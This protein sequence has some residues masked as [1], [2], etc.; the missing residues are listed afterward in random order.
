MQ[1][2]SRICSHLWL[3]Q[4]YRRCSA[5]C[6]IALLGINVWTS[7]SVNPL[8]AWAEEPSP[9]TP[10]TTGSSIEDR[11][12]WNPL[13]WKWVPTT[14]EIQKY[15]KSWNP[16]A[17]GPI[18]ISGV[19]IQPEGQFLFQPFVFGEFGHQKFGNQFST[20]PSD[21]PVH[22]KAVAPTGI[23][24]Y[25]ITNHLEV[26]VAFSGIYW[27]AS[28][29]NN[30]GGRTSESET[31]LG[32]TTIYLKYRPIVQDPEGWRP[33]LTIY[34][35]IALPSSEWAG[36]QGIPGGFSPLGRLPATRFGA[37][38]F[39]EGL[40]FRKN[41][42]PFRISGGVFYTYTAPGNTA[43][44]NTYPGD[45]IN[46]RLIIEH[47]LNDDRGFGYNLE[48]VTLNGLSHRL[49]GKTVNVLPTNYALVGVQPTLQ[50]KFFHDSNGALVG[51]AGVLFTVA[52]QNNIDAIYPN[53]SLYYYWG[54][55]GAPQ[56]R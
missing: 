17:N 25:G 4:Q 26:N 5:V 30:S 36:T 55:K 16:M 6:R 51:A 20:N 44:M 28:K 14:E 18:L 33:S 49:D 46:G 31:G 45:I 15:R 48:F 43:G 39:T 54:K 34:N 35:Q 52:G 37:L 7:L 24:A 1:L 29:A 42:Q 11:T 27:E 19:D 21:S 12:L 2:F 32:D 56:M 13:T 10:A 38:S 9:Q 50:Y 47:I 3:R 23:F 8:S 40:M 41:L 53:I 22:L